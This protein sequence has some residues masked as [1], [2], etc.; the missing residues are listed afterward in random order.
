MD[1]T[2]LLVCVG[3]AGLFLA[4]VRFLPRQAT[5]ARTLVIALGILVSARY[6]SWRLLATVLS[7]D[8]I[9]PAGIWYLLI[10]ACEVVGFVNQLLLHLILTCVT[11][12]SRQADEY[13]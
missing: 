8:V 7:E 2:P 13:E 3:V 10:Y 1:F 11:D 5:W 9:S 4:V 12:R 6:L